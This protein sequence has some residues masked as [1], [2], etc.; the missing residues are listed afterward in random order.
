MAKRPI[1]RWIRR[2]W[3]AAGLLFIGWLV[4]N[5]QAS[6]VP[7]T[8]LESSASLLVT[9]GA[10]GV[11]F[12]PVDVSAARPG[13]I[14]LPGGGIDPDAYIPFTR[15]VAEAGYPVALVRLPWRLAPTE[16]QRA[17]VWRRIAAVVHAWGDRPAVLA[18]HSRGAALA[19]RFAAEHPETL[20][21][22][23]LIA[24]THPRDEDL[25]ALRIPVMK[26]LGSNDCVAPPEGA[27]ANAYNL[28]AGTRWLVIDGAN[29]AQFG[30]YGSQL[31]DCSPSI[32]REQQQAVTRDAL[33]DLLAT[34]EAG[35]PAYARAG[36]P[37][38]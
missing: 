13:L 16:G 31:N 4:W 34:V 29:H 30:H 19:G 2:I 1:R 15:A 5:S 7:D 35:V 27:R 11:Q 10:D 17:V 28:P 36:S 21:G 12:T 23:A 22:L 24:T 32:S 18:G 20:S 9:T 6:D 37:S 38:R 14:F 3:I 26:I 8:L 25:S 33:L